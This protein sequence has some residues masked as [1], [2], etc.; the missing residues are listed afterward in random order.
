MYELNEQVVYPGY[1]V[2]TVTKIVEKII[3][4]SITS[5]YQLHFL[6]KDMTVLVSMGK[7]ESI[8]LRSLSSQDNIKSIFQTLAQPTKKLTIYELNASNWNKRQKEY[9][10]KLRSG[11]LLDISEI[12]RDLKRIAQQKELS[13][14]EK[15]LLKQTEAL[16]VEEISI[17]NKVDEERAMEDL[18]SVFNIINKPANISQKTL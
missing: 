5:F 4:G 14:G 17:V 3:S 18:R 1:G 7:A 15:D 16:L 10:I 12:Y 9:Q 2:A 11:N 6:N 13:F 8:G